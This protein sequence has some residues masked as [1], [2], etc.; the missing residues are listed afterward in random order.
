MRRNPL[1]GYELYGD[2]SP[3]R[4]SP[5]LRML[6]GKNAKAVYAKEL[7][8]V[9]FP[10]RLVVVVLDSSVRGERFREAVTHN[11]SVAMREAALT[12]D[13]IVVSVI[14]EMDPNVPQERDPRGSPFRVSPM[15]PFT[16][17]HR[18][19]DAIIAGN[20]S[21]MAE[22]MGP[23]ASTYSDLYKANKDLE[24]EAATLARDTLINTGRS[25][26]ANEHMLLNSQVLSVGVETA[27]GRMGVLGDPTQVL[28][29]LFALRSKTGRWGYNWQAQPNLKGPDYA[30]TAF[31]PKMMAARQAFSDTGVEF[32]SDLISGLKWGGYA[33]SI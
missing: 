19:Y 33:F 16:V 3:A 25:R 26:S 2:T 10:L 27:A 9:P 22:I 14:P 31:S 4:L 12:G 29:D 21:S 20:G 32:I 1:T 5:P 13:N 17:L 11:L 23:F 30:I 24:F 7:E 6:V 8:G 28:A 15:T 18:M